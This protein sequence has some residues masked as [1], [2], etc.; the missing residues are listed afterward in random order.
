MK[1]QNKEIFKKNLIQNLIIIDCKWLRVQIVRKADE[2]KLGNNN[3]TVT[4]TDYESDSDAH[5]QTKEIVQG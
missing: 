1:F 2:P 5:A 4:T 3:T